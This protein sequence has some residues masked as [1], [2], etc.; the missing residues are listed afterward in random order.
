MPAL[1][2]FLLGV[3]GLYWNLPQG[4][5]WAVSQPNATAS[6][7]NPFSTCLVEIPVDTW[8]N[9][10]QFP[11]L[12]GSPENC[13]KNWDGVYAHL[14][15]V[16]QEPQELEL[17]GSVMMDACVF[18]NYSYNKTARR[19]QN[20][21]ATGNVYHNATA[22]CNYTAL[23]ASRSSVARLALPPGVFLI[24]GDS[25]W[26]GIPSKLNGGLCNLGCLT[27]LPPNISMILTMTRKHKRVQRTVHQFSRITESTRLERTLKII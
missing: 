15:Q 10:L 22:C 6:P 27:L 12:C 20:V 17:L 3:F 13:T 1:A 24:C 5:G 21:N 23:N 26:G 4:E 2:G 7:E 14:L 19:G 8:P 11:N 16:T 9:P 18:F 25:A